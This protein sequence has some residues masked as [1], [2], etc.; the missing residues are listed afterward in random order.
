MM[1]R[2]PKW[3]NGIGIMLLVCMAVILAACSPAAPPANPTPAGATNLPSPTATQAAPA[4][5][6]PATATAASATAT[7]VPPSPTSAATA[8]PPTPTTAALPTA[9]KAVAVVPTATQAAAV[10]TVDAALAAHGKQLFTAEGCVICHGKQGE[11]VSAPKIAGT[12]LTLEQV[13]HQIR[14]PRAEMPA[15]TPE[16]LS[17]NDIRAIYAYLQ[18]LGQ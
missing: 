12:K 10:P 14:Q 5:S 4:T 8:L 7:S 18:A 9:T 3:W 2:L 15:F 1:D 13:M 17:D 6:V 16:Q 11:G